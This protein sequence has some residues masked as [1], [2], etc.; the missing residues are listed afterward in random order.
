MQSS[1]KEYEALKS[2]FDLIKERILINAKKG[3]K[4]Q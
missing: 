3:N 2:E 4:P 1:K